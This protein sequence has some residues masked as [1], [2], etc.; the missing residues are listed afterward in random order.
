MRRFNPGRERR[1]IGALIAATLLVGTGLVALLPASAFDGTNDYVALDLYESGAGSLPEFTAEAWVNTTWNTG[2]AFDNWSILD[3]DRSEFFNMF[4]TGDGRLGFGSTSPGNLNDM[5]AG[6]AGTLNDGGWH[7]IAVVYDGVDKIAY[8]DG[9]EVGRVTNAHGGQAIGHQNLTRY[10]FIGDGSE[11]TTFNGARNNI[12]YAG[13]I[14]EV[15]YWHTARTADE[16]AQNTQCVFSGVEQGLVAAYDFDSVTAG[17]LPDSAS[18]GGANHGTLFNH[19]APDGSHTPT[20]QCPPPN[21]TSVTGP[22]APVAVGE[23]V[24]ID[25]AASDPGGDIATVTRDWGDG[26]A[27]GLSTHSYNAPGVYTVTVTVTDTEGLTDSARFE[28]VVVYDATGGSVTGGGWINSPAGAYAGDPS[29]TGK[30]S[31]GF[32]SKYR[33][34]ANVPTGQTQFQFRAGDLDFHS[35]SYEWLV[36]AGSNAKYKGDGTINGAGDYGFMLTACD[37]AI[38]GGCQGG[39]DD[40]FRIKI[41]DKDSGNGVVYDN[42]P[43]ESDDSEAGTALGGGNIRIHKK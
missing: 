26:S 24:T 19:V 5:Y 28:Y 9:L 14:D 11:A 17:T 42:Q 35:D 23:Q 29:L 7:H 27:D 41:W 4:V 16:I 39:D 12:Y 15:R 38:A 1:L 8:I 22:T 3:F 6:A 10:A 43:D 40:T 32:V 33:K 21:I 20:G 18:A 31:F 13:L 37:A 36:V 25:V 2:G 34:G 30:A